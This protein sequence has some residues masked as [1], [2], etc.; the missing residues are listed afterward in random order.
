MFQSTK[1][2]D[3]IIQA[4]KALSL[5]EAERQLIESTMNYMI[6]H[7]R[8]VTNERDHAIKECKTLMEKLDAKE[9]SMS[10]AQ[11]E[12]GKSVEADIN[13]DLLDLEGILEKGETGD[14]EIL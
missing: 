10:I 11:E 1:M 3:A 12:F 7:I 2:R 9:H 13:N 14:K 5:V 4:Q 6:R 8:R